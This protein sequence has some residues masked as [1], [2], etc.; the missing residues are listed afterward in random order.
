MWPFIAGYIAEKLAR[1]DPFVHFSKM[2]GQKMLKYGTGENPVGRRIVLNDVLP[3]LRALFNEMKGVKVAILFGSIARDGASSHDVDIALL[4]EENLLYLGY[5]VSKVAEALG[6]SEDQVDVVSMNQ[7]NPIFLSRILREGVLIKGEPEAVE[8]LLEKAQR[9]PDAIIELRM[10][11]NIDPKLDKT[12]ITSRVEEI[13][14][15]ADFIKSEIL[16]KRVE[17][18]DYKEILALERAMQRI[19]ESILDICRHL[20]SVYSLGL[21]ESYGEYPKRLAEAKKMPKDIAEEIEKL[22]GLRNILVH[23]YLKVKREM[24]YDAAKNTVNE[25]INRF[26]EWVKEIDP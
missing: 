7:C 1:H 14:R 22:A 6:I 9:S 20:V 17:D 23:R 12:I 15:D 13:R 25:I 21:V 18:L 19:I 16:C 3:K 24:L 2:E 5:V 11:S 8:K 26:I 4:G 10:W